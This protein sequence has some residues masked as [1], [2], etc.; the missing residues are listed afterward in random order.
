[1]E[2]KEMTKKRKPLRIFII[3]ALVFLI[4]FIG[5]LVPLSGKASKQPALPTVLQ[6]NQ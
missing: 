1:M 2:R 4:V 6:M 5:Q 3:L